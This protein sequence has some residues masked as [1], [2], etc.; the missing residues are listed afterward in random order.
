M[1]NDFGNMLKGRI[2]Q[3][4]GSQEAFV[5]ELNEKLEGK[6][7][8]RS[9]VSAWCQLTSDVVECVSEVLGTDCRKFFSR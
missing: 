9:T 7:I 2:I 8:N 3:V 6:K 4:C 1:V 5:D